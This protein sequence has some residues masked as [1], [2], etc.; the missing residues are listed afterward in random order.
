MRGGASHPIG[1]VSMKRSEELI[2]LLDLSPHPEG[3][4]Y[5][6][7]HESSRFV[8]IPD[9]EGSRSAVTT[10][11]YLLLEGQ[12][13]RWHQID[14]DEVWHHYEGDGLELHWFFPEASVL[15]SERLGPA[16]GIGRPQAVVPADA[17]QT[18]RPLGSY[19]LVGCTVAPGFVFSKFRLL[20]DSE[21]IQA[22]VRQRW[23]EFMRYV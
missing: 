12:I 11:Y 22:L 9:T 4:Y 13:S 19:A 8:E 23:P 5:R 15:H 14:S 16:E 1:D 21:R 6:Q 2:S 3:G 10:I 7:I 20:S 17:W 18:A